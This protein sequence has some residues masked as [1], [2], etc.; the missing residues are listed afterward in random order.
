[1]A[2]LHE[3]IE[4]SSVKHPNHY[5]ELNS[6]RRRIPITRKPGLHGSP[7]ETVFIPVAAYSVTQSRLNTSPRRINPTPVKTTESAVYGYVPRPE[8]V[9]F[10]GQYFY[11]PNQIAAPS[12]AQP[13][14]SPTPTAASLALSGGGGGGG[15]RLGGLG[16]G[17][18]LLATLPLLLA[19]MLSYLFTP[20]II[21]VTATIAA[22][23]KRKKRTTNSTAS[24]TVAEELSKA[25]EAI[26]R[27]EHNE[28]KPFFNYSFARI[29]SSDDK[30]HSNKMNAK[31]LR[32]KEV[33]VVIDYLRKVHFDEKH[34]DKAIANYLQCDGLL[35]RDDHCLERLSCE[36]S[37]PLNRKASE[38]DRDVTAILLGHILNNS[39]ITNGLKRKLKKAAV[40]GRDNSGRCSVFGC[41]KVL[42]DYMKPFTAT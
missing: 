38:L 10:R 42:N 11:G 17:G 34:R 13:V 35:E 16:P 1:M 7:S 27:S 18:L 28:F 3:I 2:D 22:G 29:K 36:F 31:E 4:N 21:P 41:S 23:R 26:M 37:D 12:V 8:I 32:L 9:E 30:K 14:A 25:E 6:Q 24:E 40:F 20:M 39:Y 15:K 19:P 33:Q 5:N